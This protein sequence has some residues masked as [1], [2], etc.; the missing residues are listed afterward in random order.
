MSTVNLYDVLNVDQNCNRNDLKRSY[1]NLVKVFHPDMP[2]GDEE[3]FEL[4]THAYN[5]LSNDTTR[6]EY[7]ELFML[8]KGSGNNHHQLREQTKNYFEAEKTSITTKDENFSKK[9][10][11]VWYASTIANLPFFRTSKKSFS[12]SSFIKP[13]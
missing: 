2:N 12:C 8:S 9:D 13:L 10:F 7:D 11:H 4:I 1:R 3:M 6:C 5:I